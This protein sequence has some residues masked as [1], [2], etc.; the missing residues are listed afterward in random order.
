[1]CDGPMPDMTAI[2]SHVL[3]Y[4][5]KIGTSDREH[6]WRSVD[7][8]AFGEFLTTQTRDAVPEMVGVPGSGFL[9]LVQNSPV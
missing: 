6:V 8:S 9:G 7:L 5:M 1:M 3:Q 2:V 4:G